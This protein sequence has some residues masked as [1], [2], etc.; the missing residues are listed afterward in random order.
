MHMNSGDTYEGALK[1]GSYH[2]H[3][4]YIWKQ[5]SSWQTWFEGK[6]LLGFRTGNGRQ[7]WLSRKHK[8]VYNGLFAG[9]VKTGSGNLTTIVNFGIT[10][11]HF[12][13]GGLSS[14][15]SQE[16]RIL[17]ESPQF[18]KMSGDWESDARP[19][20]ELEEVDPEY[21]CPIMCPKFLT[22]KAVYFTEG[23]TCENAMIDDICTTKCY[24]GYEGPPIEF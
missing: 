9:G 14:K 18:V 17:Y 13:G 2:G 1:D 15:D 10:E 16:A 23:T 3:G 12:L 19:Q 11:T 8:S 24:T 5:E 21:V 22:Q 20:P 4:K 6:W 7:E